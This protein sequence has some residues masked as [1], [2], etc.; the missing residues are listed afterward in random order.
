MKKKKMI[1][2]IL[3]YVLVIG[4]S[5]ISAIYLADQRDSIREI[6]G[7][8]EGVMAG[9]YE[10]E[11][12]VE[13][14]QLVQDSILNTEDMD[15]IR[16]R[17]AWLILDM[18]TEVE[19]VETSPPGQSGVGLATWILEMLDVGA[20]QEITFVGIRRAEDEFIDSLFDDLVLRIIGQEGQIYYIWY[21]RSLGLKMVREENE[22]G[23]LLYLRRFHT[24]I[25]GKICEPEYPGGPILSCR[26]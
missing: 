17:N 10:I 23:E 13:Q 4:A 2:L 25:D 20:I 11:L 1:F 7:G 24:I 12:T 9:M 3:I 6:S 14:Y 19:F 5:I 22:D 18:I 15:E 21:E 26:E 8:Y 16:L